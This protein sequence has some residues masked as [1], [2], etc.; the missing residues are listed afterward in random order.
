MEFLSSPKNYNECLARLNIATFFTTLSFFVVLR[1]FE[2]VPQIEI[3]SKLIPPMKDYKELI[4][5]IL[6]FGIVPLFAAGIAFFASH[7]F[8]LHNKVADFL[9]IKIFWSER[10]IIQPLKR[11]AQVTVTLNPD[12][13]KKIMNE[14]YY[15]GTKK[16]DEHHVHLFWR[17]ATYFWILFEHIIVVFITA[18]ILSIFSWSHGVA[19][20][21]LY[22]FLMA[23]LAG[24]HFF[25]IVGSKSTKQADEISDNEVVDFFN[26]LKE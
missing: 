4:E 19:Y 8:E 13:R 22:F 12:N 1:I 5:W 24:L 20:L 2:L 10:F 26:N 7:F 11:R 14:L 6:S 25:F 21:W 17:Y 16:I 15:P 9:R 23:V 3:P 18:V